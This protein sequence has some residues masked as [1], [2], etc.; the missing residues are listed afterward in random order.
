VLLRKYRLV[1]STDFRRANKEGQSWSDRLIVLCKAPNGLPLSRF[2]FSVS[3]RI[4]KATVRNR[5]RRLMR[6]AVRLQ[7]DL[8][9]PGWDVVLIAR[10]GMVGASY[11]AVERSITYLL[12]LASLR[13]A[14]AGAD[15]GEVE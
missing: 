5:A 11:W 8:I 4:G 13:R 12:S 14:E 1:K 10:R 7:L 15:R 6:E 2:G 3:R 9:S